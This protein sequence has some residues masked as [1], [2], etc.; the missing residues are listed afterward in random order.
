[1]L[2]LV[3]PSLLKLAKQ[4]HPLLVE[5]SNLTDFMKEA[6]VGLVESCVPW[7]PEQYADFMRNINSWGREVVK[8][9]AMNC[10][11]SNPLPPFLIDSAFLTEIIGRAC[12]NLLRKPKIRSTKLCCP[13]WFQV[14]AHPANHFNVSFQFPTSSF[15]FCRVVARDRRP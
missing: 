13:L 9:E 10:A 2:E 5:S 14:S 4:P 6:L 11:C 7:D 1:M 15:S 12:S 8:Q 3:L